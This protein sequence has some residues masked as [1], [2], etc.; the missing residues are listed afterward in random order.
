MAMKWISRFSPWAAQC[1]LGG[2]GLILITVVSF[3]IGLTAASA[4]FA[5]L[6]LIVPLSLL[7][8]FPASAILSIAAAASLA[9]FF[10]PPMLE[11]VLAMVAFTTASLVITALVARRRNLTLATM[12][13]QLRDLI[14]AIPAMAWTTLADGSNGFV[15]TRWTE[16]TGLSAQEMAGEGWQAVVHP[17]DAERLLRKWSD[18]VATGEPLEDEVRFRCAAANG[19]YRWFLIRGAPLRGDHGNLVRWY[20]IFIDI[21]DRKRAEVVLVAERRV[22]EMVAKG[23]SLPR[24]L[25]SLCRLVEENTPDALASVFLLE[26]GYLKLGAAPSLPRAYIEAT[27]GLA[28]GPS[29]GSC[30]TA[31]Y[32]AKRVIV[33]DIATDALWADYREAALAHSLRACWSTPIR[34][35]DGDVIGTFAMYYREPRSPSSR[36]QE[37]VEQI[38]HLAGVAIQRKL[39]EQRLQRSQAY[40][41][42][43]QRLTQTGSWAWDVGTDKVVHWSGEMFRMLGFGPQH[44]A[45]AGD[46]YLQRIHPEERDRIF[47]EIQAAV[48][49]KRDFIVEHRIITGDGTVRY[50]QNIGHPLLDAAGAI[51]EYVGTMIDVTDRKHAEE[52]RE[53]LRLLEADIAHMNR[54]STLGELAAT[55]AHEINQPITAAIT[56]ANACVRWLTR[57]QPDLNEARGAAMRIVGDSTRA[58]EIISRVRS[59]YKKGPPPHRELLD[60]NDVA[61]EILT[62]VRDEANRYSIAIHTELA[63]LP[64]VRA[65]RVQLQQVFMNLMLNGIEAMKETAGELTIKSQL[66]DHDEQLISVS[67]TG[68]GLPPGKTDQIF[69]SF[70]TTKPQGSGMGLTIS[71]SIVESYGGRLWAADNPGRGATFYFTLP[72]EEA[73][74]ARPAR[75]SGACSR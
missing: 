14:E 30:G 10:T 36:D 62:L 57:D 58:A 23:D 7:G 53:K 44:T 49:Q 15:N 71:R 16:H 22:L 20:G 5:Y 2:I 66:G 59:F 32:F 47:E 72:Q 28:V 18:A 24:I 19:Q 40:L 34:S 39:T 67:D 38:T 21:E 33:S 56:N 45:M 51:T 29:V 9:Y 61:R 17:E 35:P 25:D 4:G 73:A 55:L 75:V 26:D 27:D 64:Q 6:L 31:A 11:G 60:V 12:E 41:A 46:V 54:V 8:S 74:Y 43:A 68:V 69:S 65:D 37:I 13:A 50:F 70:F 42:E 63:D 48:E 3:R 1:G 52:E